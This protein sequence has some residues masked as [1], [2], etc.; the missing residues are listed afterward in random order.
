MF[1]PAT[2]VTAGLFGCIAVAVAPLWPW[3]RGWSW[4]PF[5]MIAMGTLTYVVFSWSVVPV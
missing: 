1:S 4:A 5:A 3:S 2:L